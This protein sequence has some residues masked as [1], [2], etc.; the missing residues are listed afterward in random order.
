MNNERPLNVMF[1]SERQDWGTPDGFLD[2]LNDELCL[3]FD[4]DAAASDDNH[5]APS[6][7]TI[8][9]DGLNCEWWGRV[10]LNPP[11]GRELPLWLEKCVQEIRREE[12]ESI[13]VLIPARTDTKWFHEIVVPNA[14]A[15]Y[16]IKGRFNFRFDRAIEGAN[17]PFPS[18][19][20]HFKRDMCIDGSAAIM[21]LEVP[22]ISRGF[23]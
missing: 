10:W 15:I 12:V 14:Y 2:F 6:Y 11:F 20:V 16:L 18:M 7:F 8:E 22:K 19:L 9:D 4:L 23:Q 5:K 1:K 3:R 17:A 13:H 21:T